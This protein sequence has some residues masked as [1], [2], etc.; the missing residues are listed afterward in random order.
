MENKSGVG[1]PSKYGDLRYAAFLLDVYPRIYKYFS[2]TERFAEL[3]T[4]GDS[5]LIYDGHK[6]FDRDKSLGA[7]S[8][9]WAHSGGREA[10]LQSRDTGYVDM[11]FI[12]CDDEYG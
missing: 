6:G 10:V 7:R 1:S 9:R 2:D 3:P 11:P 5:K 8:R 12:R 4:N